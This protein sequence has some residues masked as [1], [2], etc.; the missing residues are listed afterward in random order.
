MKLITFSDTYFDKDLEIF[1]NLPVELQHNIYEYIKYDVFIAMYSDYTWEK[2]LNYLF[3]QY[4][5][6]CVISILNEHLHKDYHINESEMYDIGMYEEK[7]KRSIWGKRYI[8]MEDTVKNEDAIELIT[9]KMNSY[10]NSCNYNSFN[11]FNVYFKLIS[12]IEY[13]DDYEINDDCDKHIRFSEEV[14]NRFNITY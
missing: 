5:I 2:G 11:L 3:N 4:Y 9:D 13:I 1:K 7:V 8:W 6:E 14:Y 12:M 10:I